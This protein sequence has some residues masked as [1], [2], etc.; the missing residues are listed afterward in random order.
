ML[1]QLK[2]T[3]AAFSEKVRVAANVQVG[4]N[5]HQWNEIA[6]LGHARDQLQQQMS[7]CSCNCSIFNYQGQRC[8]SGR[9]GRCLLSM[10]ESTIIFLVPQSDYWTP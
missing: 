7:S 3:R 1:S 4:I 6:F 9:M 5:T 2:S 10:G 8:G